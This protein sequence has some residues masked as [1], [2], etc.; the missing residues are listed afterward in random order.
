MMMTRRSHRTSFA[1]RALS[2]AAVAAVAAPVAAETAAADG[3]TY[4]KDIAPILQRSCQHCHRPES[5]A[6]MSLLTYEDARPWA[7]AM[8]YR[9][10]RG[11]QPD[12]M[13]P[14]Y[15][16]KDI[17]IQ[18]YKGDIS[19][20]EEEI[21]KIAAWADSGAPRGDPADLPAPIT[22]TDASGWEIGEPDLVLKSPEIEVAPTAPD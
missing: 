22:F 17:G 5:V 1:L 4:T 14:W 19:L 6:P 3:A 12:V 18:Q 21:A 7:R 20:S 10:G 11:S 16:E 15:I 8:K 13:P 9:T 2:V